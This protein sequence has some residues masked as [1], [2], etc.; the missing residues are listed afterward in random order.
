MTTQAIS[1]EPRPKSYTTKPL[2][3]KRQV[4]T[5]G[6]I[7]RMCQAAPRT[8]SKWFD[9]GKL[10]G[11]RIPGSKG[12]RVPRM[13][14]IRF[15]MD[16]GMP[17]RLLGSHFSRAML[18]GTDPILEQL[19][20]ELRTSLPADALEIDWVS[21]VFKAGV[22]SVTL[23]PTVVVADASIGRD[24]AI[25]LGKSVR[26]QFHPQLMLGLA[27]EDDAAVDFWL[28]SGFDKVY[29]RPFDNRLIIADIARVSKDDKS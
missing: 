7:A 3:T 9:S 28:D 1:S 16:N 15:M 5:T 24:A 26:E 22:L 20:H 21:D 12:R 14:L 25:Q 17:L 13:E 23:E 8:I 10:K 29:K 4:F 6:Q 18:V 2:S 11:Y 27:F 19:C